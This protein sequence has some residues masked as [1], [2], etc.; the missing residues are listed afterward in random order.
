MSAVRSRLRFPALFIAVVGLCLACVE[1]VTYLAPVPLQVSVS[2]ELLHLRVGG[3]ATLQVSVERPIGEQG[4]QRALEEELVLTAERLPAGISAEPAVIAAGE[5]TGEITLRASASMTAGLTYPITL[6]AH[7]AGGEGRT[8]IPVFLLGK[9]GTVDGL[10]PSIDAMSSTLV[11]LAHA[12][13]GVLYAGDTLQMIDPHGHGEASFGVNGVAHF[14]GPVFGEPRYAAGRWPARAAYQS[15]GKLVVAM[16]Y[17]KIRSDEDGILL[18]RVLPDGTVD[19]TFGPSGAET[20]VEI[21]LPPGGVLHFLRMLPSDELMLLAGDAEDT[22]TIRYA[23]TRQGHVRSKVSRFID[24]TLRSGWSD[25]I[26]QADD[27]L[28]VARAEGLT[29]FN[30]DLSLDTFFG[31][32][33]TLAVGAGPVSLTETPGGYLAA[34]SSPVG[35]ALWRFDADWSLIDTFTG[36]P[37]AN[38]LGT[39]VRGYLLGGAFVTLVRSLHARVVRFAS[40]GSLDPTFG[41]NGVLDLWPLATSDRLLALIPSTH[42]RAFVV[43][44]SE[45]RYFVTRIWL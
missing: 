26:V 29:R 3:E 9:P 1:R 31:D 27:K 37:T 15:D 18:F 41:Q 8:S 20:A 7:G 4:E 36:E 42:S 38:P 30:L 13:G 11:P 45:Q 28:V 32:G 12:R 40:D 5:R 17:K 14:L 34:G 19:Q 24:A 39:A 16:D 44:Q 21:P 10:L 35:A 2:S 23:V 33:G 22:Q 25:V 6:A 43:V